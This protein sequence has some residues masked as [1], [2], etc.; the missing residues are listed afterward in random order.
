MEFGPDGCLY[1]ADWYNKIISHNELPRT[2]SERDKGH[3]RIWRI[4]HQSQIPGK[5]PNLY[6]TP[7]S[8]LV[9]HLKAPPSGRNALHGTK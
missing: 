2:H 8:D 5:I 1:I 3:G 6:E 9:S 7:T 4:R